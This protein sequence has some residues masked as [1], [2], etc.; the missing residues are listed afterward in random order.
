MEQAGTVT[1][2]PRRLRGR[3]LAASVL[4][5]LAL[6]LEPAAAETPRDPVSRF[7]QGLLQAMRSADDGQPRRR[8][9]ALQRMLEGSFDLAAV[10]REVIALHWDSLQAPTREALTARIR[11]YAVAVLADRFV[12]YSSERFEPQVESPL[13]DRHTRVRS[14][15]VDADGDTTQ[16]DYVVRDTAVGPRIV[17]VYFDGVSGTDIQRREFAAFLREGGAQALLRRL[18]ALIADL[19]Q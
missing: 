12:G 19:A 8:H 13:D 15:F 6:A 7:E 3:V 4:V 16:L 2:A 14:L 1:V 11:D 9:D 5:A 18:D 17:N 10:A